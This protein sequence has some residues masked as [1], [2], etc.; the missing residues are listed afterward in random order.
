MAQTTLASLPGQANLAGSDTGLY[1]KMFA[2][3]VLTTFDERRIFADYVRMKN[4]GAGR[5]H[6]FPATGTADATYHVRGEDILDPANDYL[7]EIESGERTIQVDKP[8]V[9]PVFT[10]NWDQLISHY[11]TRSEWARQCGEAIANKQDRSI[12]QVIALTARQGATLSATQDPKKAGSVLSEA[13]VRETPSLMIDQMVKAATLFVEKDVPMDDVIFCVR[14][15]MYY[16]LVQNGD[17]LNTDFGNAGNGSQASGGVMKGY[18]FKIMHSNHIP[19]TTVAARTGELNNYA[20]DFRRTQ[21]LAWNRQ[22]VGT[23]VRQGMVVETEKSVRHQGDLLVAKYTVGTGSLRP[24]CAIE[25]IDP[26]TP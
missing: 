18:G 24:E 16:Q 25:I 4:V 8:L 1:L 13:G 5:S 6:Q 26:E 17:L 15:S 2:G 9:A 10:D 19:S 11:E 23:V 22:A 20:G 14:P 3:E 21:A 7:N 12:A